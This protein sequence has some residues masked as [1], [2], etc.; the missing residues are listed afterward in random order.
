MLPT[1]VDGEPV[2]AAIFTKL[3]RKV[4]NRVRPFLLNVFGQPYPVDLL[5]TGVIT[6]VAVEAETNDVRAYVVSTVGT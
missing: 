2:F 5:P 4:R 1:P 6:L 3:L